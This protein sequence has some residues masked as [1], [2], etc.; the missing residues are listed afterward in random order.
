[1]QPETPEGCLPH[2]PAAKQFAVDLGNDQVPVLG[3]HC[4]VDQQHIAATHTGPSHRI[5]RGA[6]HEGGLRVADQRI[7]EVDAPD[8]EVAAG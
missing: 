3:R 2:K 4:A 6:H 7:V 1:M 5:T 8:G